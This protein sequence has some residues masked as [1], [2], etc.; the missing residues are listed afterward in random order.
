[1]TSIQHYHVLFAAEGVQD[2][3]LRARRMEL[4]EEISEESACTL[5][6]VL[7]GGV[8][9]P[10]SLLGSTGRVTILAE[11]GARVVRYF[12][13]LIRQVSER[14]GAG[15]ARQVLRLELRS[16][17]AALEDSTDS[18]IY[19]DETT[20]SI[21]EKVFSAAGIQA[22]RLLWR[23]GGTLPTRKT[24][25]QRGES[26]RMFVE[27][28][29]EED[30]VCWF[31]E[32]GDA[33]Q[34]IV[35][36]DSATGFESAEADVP[37]G[38]GLGLLGGEYLRSVHRAATVS[39]NK[40]TL[41]DHDFTKPNIDLTVAAEV[42]TA[43]GREHYEYPGGYKDL[44]SGRSRVETL[45]A[46]TM[47][48][49]VCAGCLGVVPSM[50]TGRSV[51]IVDTPD[52]Q[53]DGEY[54][55]VAVQH[56]WEQRPGGATKLET[57]AR[58]LEGGG[59]FA[60]LPRLRRP[61]VAGELAN[62]TT[63]PGEEIHCDEHGRVKVQF[64]WDR[65]GQRDDKSSG[66]VRVAQMHTSGSVVVPRRT[67]EM[68]IEFEDG[69]LEQPI[70]LGR[71]YNAS[72]P[73]TDALPGA[74]T[75]SVLKSYSTPGGGGHNEIRTADSGGSELVTVNAQKDLNLVVANDKQEKIATSASTQVTAAHSLTVGGSSTEQVGS[76][77]SVTIGGSHTH[78]VGASRSKTVS[79]SETHEVG[80]SRS[81][82]IGGSHTTMT[83]MADSTSSNGSL[84]ETV[85]GMCLEVAALGVGLAVAGSTSITVG[86]AKI[87]AVATGK[88]DMTV[89]A[90]A[91]TVGGA[92]INVTPKDVTL[93]TQG[94]KVTTVGG[95][96]LGNAGGNVEISSAADI[97]VTVGGAI[98]MNGAKIVFKVGSSTVTISGGAVILDSPDVKLTATGPMAELAGAPASK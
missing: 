56:S 7:D 10:R 94:V 65:Y 76:A 44:A 23:L 36:T 6:L 32:H 79:G 83:P 62:V 40:L 91:S 85:S 77:E 25:T 28:L 84:S 27:R 52:A 72:S 88:S 80:G 20:K 21:V 34:K 29:L 58:L 63:P 53:S 24:T 55:P 22:D 90:R 48:E 66:F 17:F 73:P 5:E 14:A 41:R 96:W 46:A 35:F 78:K 11:D 86:A 2:G 12:Y 64:L 61:V 57:Q 95:A 42:E 93:D 49:A 16:L 71:L 15:D 30:G 74:K 69:D 75:N 45:R 68:C 13:G 47:A 81:L 67:W 70:A 4:R 51:R 19:F 54:V 9:D 82:S 18:R 37:Y 8:L 38:D 60:R 33:G 39:P 26:M 92:F 89:G 50:S 31:I 1:M 59:R 97:S 43:L 87:E 98:L 3:L